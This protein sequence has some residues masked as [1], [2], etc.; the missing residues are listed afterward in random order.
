MG[1]TIRDS[2]DE[3][4]S[5]RIHA[6]SS[7][8]MGSASTE[9][10]L[11]TDGSEDCPGLE[12]R[13]GRWYGSGSGKSRG[14]L[15]SRLDASARSL[16][17]RYRSHNGAK[18][19]SLRSKLDVS[20]SLRRLPNYD[21]LRRPSEEKEGEGS[22]LPGAKWWHTIFLFSLISMLACIITLWAPYPI[23]ARMPTEMVAGMPWSNGCQGLHSCICPRET[24]CAD[25]LVSMVF[26]TIARS[27]AWFDYP[28]YMLLFLSK[29][30]NLNNFLQKT[31][32]RCWINFSDSHR[33]HS[34]FGVVVGIESLSHSFFHLLR[35]ARRNND[36]QLLWTTRTGVTGLV[37]VSLIPFIVLPM[38]VPYLKTRM[39]YEW[40]KGLHYLSA[41]WGVALMCHAPERIFFL[42]G[43]PLFVYV[44]DKVVGGLFKTHLVES[45]HFQR[46]GDTSCLVSFENP[47]GFGKQ[48]SA[49]VYLMLPWLSKYQFHAFTI[50]PSKKSGHTSVCIDKAGDWTQKLMNAVTTPT[51][52][53]AFVVGP[54]LSPFSSP[55]MDSENLV[56]VASG[57]GVTPAISLVRKYSNTSRRLNLVWICRDPGLVEEFLQNVDFGSDGYTLI[58]YTGK[59]RGLILRDDLPPNVLVF[60]GRPNLERTL[61]GIIAS[62]ATGEGLP[63]ELTHKKVLTRTPAELRSTLLLEKALSIYTMDQ[64]FDYSAKASHYHQQGP[65]PLVT[66]VNY[67]GVLSTMKHLLG[68]DCLLVSDKIARNFEM[69]DP[70]GDGRLDR[71]KFEELF[72]LMINKKE[73]LSASMVDAIGGLQRMTTCR[74]LFNSSGQQTSKNSRKD[75]FGI[76][77]H[78]QGE[79]KF[80]ARNWNLLYCG[81]SQ[82]V[83]D[84][85]K[86]FKRKFGIDL[87][88][89]KFDW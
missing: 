63:E 42:V 52:K 35:W 48:N 72:H 39:S 44:A 16:S 5:M 2:L 79:G 60:N 65:E 23:G 59:E 45:A 7:D 9:P 10:T 8:E 70:D 12:S 68:E 84:Q 30:H 11:S 3:A 27:T 29:A 74:D 4:T 85:L 57:I 88:V 36:I 86:A 67:Q 82:P 78:L 41:L 17:R 46:L 61:G 18:P 53:P 19:S 15:K 76:K 80:A 38:T 43:I 37:A 56:A 24:I 49:Y 14:V 50:F 89:E 73:D 34:L 77:R 81:G 54:F 87:S 83:V 75:E 20:H 1:R 64:L 28:L 22:L 71:S 47:P 66:V 51:H 69:V 13:N 55:A 6:S 62:I 40:R 31:A 21:F 26:L 58:Y 25:D 33:V 32:L